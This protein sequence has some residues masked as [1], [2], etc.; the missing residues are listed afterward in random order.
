MSED[1]AFKI[2]L[3]VILPKL[4]QTV[5]KNISTIIEEHVTLLREG[6]LANEEP[7]SMEDIKGL[8]MQSL[9]I[10]LDNDVL[11]EID[12]KFNPVEDVPEVAGSAEEA[13][14]KEESAEAAA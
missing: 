2:Q 8:I 14:E 9:E 11:P 6:T 4:K 10:F 12:K 7:T 5:S 3:G 13:A 1:I